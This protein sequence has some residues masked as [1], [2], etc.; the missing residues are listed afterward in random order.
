ML[1]F[2]A[3]VAKSRELTTKLELSAAGAIASPADPQ[4]SAVA[5]PSPA[6]APSVESSNE[7]NEFLWL[8]QAQMDRVLARHHALVAR[9]ARSLSLYV[10]KS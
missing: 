10:E 7:G 5:A 1:G 8:K 6:P 4:A 9:C 3:F 2:K